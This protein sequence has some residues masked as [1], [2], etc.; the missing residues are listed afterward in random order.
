MINSKVGID[1]ENCRIEKLWHEI[2][3]AC[4]CPHNITGKYR[5]I[6]TMINLNIIAIND[7]SEDIKTPNDNV[8]DKYN[9]SETQSDNV[10]LAD[11]RAGGRG[12]EGEGPYYLI[13]LCVWNVCAPPPNSG[14][15]LLVTTQ[16]PHLPHNVK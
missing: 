5:I 4:A 1:W 10:T 15:F 9:R 3:N 12:A 11:Q 16:T 13:V 8:I 14:L 6:E 2:E 7:N